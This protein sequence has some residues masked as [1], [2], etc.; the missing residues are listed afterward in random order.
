MSDRKLPDKAID[1]IYET[2]ASQK[3][4]PISKRKKT[5]NQKDIEQTI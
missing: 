2:G 4:K 3:L 1:V 5:I